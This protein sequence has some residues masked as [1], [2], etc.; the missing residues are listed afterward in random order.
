MTDEDAFALS[1]VLPSDSLFPSE[2]D[3]YLHVADIFREAA[4]LS[5]EVSFTENALSVIPEDE[6]VSELWGTVIRGYTDLALYEDAY[7]ALVSSPEEDL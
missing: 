7:S 6:E 4:F 2:F 5:S 3:Y 1:S